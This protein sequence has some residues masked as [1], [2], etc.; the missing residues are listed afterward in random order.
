V[1][2]WYFAFTAAGVNVP[3]VN[4]PILYEVTVKPEVMFDGSVPVGPVTVEAAPAA[5][6]EPVGPVL[7]VGPVTVEA[8]PPA[9]C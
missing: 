5:P 4:V 3:P 9:P 8:A 6:V 2:Y 7:P 1:P